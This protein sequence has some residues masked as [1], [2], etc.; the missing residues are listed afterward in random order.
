MGT[1]SIATSISSNLNYNVNNL[2]Y[3]INNE[4][5]MEDIEEDESKRYHMIAI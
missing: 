3:N 2:N 1:L 4:I 5:Q